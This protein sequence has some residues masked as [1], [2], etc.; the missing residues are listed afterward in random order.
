MYALNRL[1]TTKKYLIS[2]Y[3]GEWHFTRVVGD[4]AMFY[5]FTFHNRRV[6]IKLSLER[7]EQAVWEQV[8]LISNLES[9]RGM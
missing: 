3:P 4:Y 5:Q 2:N 8:S 1:C 9:F 7:V 6:S